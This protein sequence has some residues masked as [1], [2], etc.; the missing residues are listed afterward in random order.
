MRS[1]RRSSTSA[2]TGPECD[3]LD[4]R[5]PPVREGLGRSDD[6]RHRAAQVDRGE[7][8][9][10]GAGVEA[11]DL[12]QVGQQQLEAVEFTLEQ[13]GRTAHDGVE[14]GARVIEEVAGHANRRQRGAQLVRDVGDEALLHPAQSFELADL[15]LEA[16]G[17]RVERRAEQGEVVLA[18]R[19]PYVR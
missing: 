5:A 13:L 17:H 2:W 9:G 15:R 12:E 3:D 7:V 10:R 19:R 8:E 1:T 6:P 4:R 18:A 16:V 14:V 11:A